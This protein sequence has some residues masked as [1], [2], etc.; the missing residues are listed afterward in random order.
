[1]IETITLTNFRN[2]KMCRI[3][4]FGRHNV[5]ITGPNGAGKTA[6]LEAISM[7]SGDRGMRGASMPE[8]ACFNGDGNFS[9]FAEL[10]VMAMRQ[11][12][13]ICLRVCAWYG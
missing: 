1:M 3:Q 2:H 8:I 5:I 10:D 4:T 6:V 11:H 13:L 12:Y 7:L 9:V